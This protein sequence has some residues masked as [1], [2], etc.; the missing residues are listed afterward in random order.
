M[1]KL[2]IDIEQ[3]GAAYGGQHLFNMCTN[4]CPFK[5]GFMV[6]SLACKECEY[7]SEHD[8]TVVYCICDERLD[9]KLPEGLFEI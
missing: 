3:Y 4:K 9:Y 5:K 2:K 6:G 1:I 7:I 8:D